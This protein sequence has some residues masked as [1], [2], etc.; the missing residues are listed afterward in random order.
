MPNVRDFYLYRE[1]GPAMSKR[2][3]KVLKAVEG[4]V[5]GRFKTALGNC[6]FEVTSA[7][8]LSSDRQE[9]LARFAQGISEAKDLLPHIEPWRFFKEHGEELARIVWTAWHNSYETQARSSSQP[10][11]SVD[12]A[13]TPYAFQV[14]ETP[15]SLSQG[16]SPNPPSTASPVLVRTKKRRA[17]R[18]IDGNVPR[19]QLN[20]VKR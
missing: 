9:R 5:D 4:W 12:S 16:D 3:K 6:S 7:C 15:I 19:R 17:L 20:R 11:L 13:S 1:Q 10:Q 18:E 8:F 2:S 14:P